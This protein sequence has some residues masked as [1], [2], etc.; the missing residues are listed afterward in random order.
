[1]DNFGLPLA[2]CRASRFLD[3][4]NVRDRVS[5]LAGGGLESPGDFLKAFA[6]GAD[7]V[8]IGTIALIAITHTQVFKA[9]PYET[10]I[11]AKKNPAK[12]YDEDQML[13]LL[14]ALEHAPLKYQVL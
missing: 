10:P 8:Y 14:D 9:L 4:E 1:M 2:F 6:L 5:L 12:C 3:H 13:A 11:K 7:G